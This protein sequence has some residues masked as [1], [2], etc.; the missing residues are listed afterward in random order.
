MAAANESLFHLKLGINEGIFVFQWPKQN[1][2][3]Y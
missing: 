1:R 3:S 2:C